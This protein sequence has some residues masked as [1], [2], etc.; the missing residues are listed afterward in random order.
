[1]TDLQLMRFHIYKSLDAIAKSKLQL[2]DCACED[3]SERIIE[4]S[5]L[6]TSAT[7]T[8]SLAGTRILLEKALQNTVEGLE[9]LYEH[10]QHDSPYGTDQLTVNTTDIKTG[11]NLS[12]PPDEKI[13]KQRIDSSLTTYGA[14]LQKVVNT[15][16]CKE[17]RAFAT[18]I[19]Q[20]CELQLL[21]SDL[22][23]GKKYYNLR[24]KEITG[25]AL[26]QMGEC[27]KE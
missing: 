1:M 9:A 12:I 10:E 6:L 18:R 19:Y 14:S 16:N 15:V 25:K 24:T 13:L 11:K 17:A 2:E 4:T 21:R 20:H 22:S 23:E 5:E 26:E 3:A 8:T 27:G 7:K